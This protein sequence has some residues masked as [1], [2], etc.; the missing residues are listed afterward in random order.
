MELKRLLEPYRAAPQVSAWMTDID[1]LNEKLEHMHFQVAVVGEFKRGKTSFINALLRKQILPADVA[2]A[3]ATINR[4]TYGDV[5]ASYIQWK[6]GRPDQQ[7]EI[8]QLSDHITKLTDSSAMQARSIKEAVVQ[9]PCRFCEN[10]VDLIDTPGMNDDDDM[11]SVTIRQL[12]NVDLAIVTLDPNFPVSNTEAVFIAQLVESDQIYQIVFAV[13]KMDTVFGPQRER[14]LELI[15]QRLRDLVREVLL[16]THTDGDE[17][18]EKFQRIFS[19]IILFPVSSTQ[20]LYAYEMGDRQALESS[21]FQKLNDELLPL[22]VRTQHSASILTPLQAVIRISKEFQQLL[23]I[24]AEKTALEDTMQT[25][26]KT[27]A[28]TAYSRHL[29]QGEL[30]WDCSGELDRQKGARCR[31]VEDTI[32]NAVRQTADSASLVACIKELFQRLSKELVKEEGDSYYQ[33]WERHFCPIYRGL[34][35][36]LIQLIQPHP[37]VQSGIL[38][39]L[40]E[41][42]RFDPPSEQL[43]SPEPFYWEM[44]P[45]PPGSMPAGQ[46]VYFVDNAVRAS[47][48]GYYQRRKAHLSNFLQAVIEEKEQQIAHL[49]QYFF[50]LAKQEDIPEGYVR[51]K[52]ETYRKLD[53][54]LGQLMHRCIAARG[55]YIRRSKN[56][57]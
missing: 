27:F 32:L 5:P 39:W 30:W 17:V 22:I 40:D 23:Q 6:D 52:H 54:A 56:E 24:W 4:I 34:K 46:I 10:N 2:P 16:K 21:G 29:D 57:R 47:F 7:V 38:P 36:Q 35:Q 25:L 12:S 3:T 1:Q 19:E 20:A 8:E 13:S 28:E 14:L 48:E 11:N 43:A 41:L 50:Q 55:D 18:M 9:Y 42:D 31:A 26:R 44:S 15:R 45:I 53:E 51:L 33:V 37:G 49:V